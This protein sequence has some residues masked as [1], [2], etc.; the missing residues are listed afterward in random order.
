[1]TYKILIVDLKK[2]NIDFKYI[3]KEIESEYLSGSALGL[4]FIKKY[5]ISNFFA[6][7]STPL[8]LIQ[9]PISK[10]SIVSTNDKGEII[11]SSMGG[12][13]G[14]YL[15]KNSIDGLILLNKYDSYTSIF[16]DKDQVSFKNIGLYGLYNSQIYK[17]INEF[18]KNQAS[19]Y[20]AKAGI[21]KD[22]TARLIHN[23][24]HGVSK[25][26]GYYLAKKNILSIS[27]KI[28]NDNENINFDFSSFSKKRLKNCSL[29]PLGCRFPRKYKNKTIFDSD[30]NLSDINKELLK[31]IKYKLDEYGLDDIALSKSISFSY[32]HLN[33]IYN[34]DNLSYA[35][36]AL[37]VDNIISDY[38]KNIYRDL[39]QGESFLK[40]KYKIDSPKSK[41]KKYNFL[42]LLMDNIGM[43]FFANDYETTSELIDF[44]NKNFDKNYN[45]DDIRILA[46]KIEKLKKL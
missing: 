28:Y 13:F 46:S 16:I 24:N 21:N 12:E 17:K 20:I 41:E 10:F 39:A 11:E 44:I 34:F 38:R 15:K 33:D 8:N 42:A 6:I 7:F 31:E 32:N 2:Q 36:L 19:I 18:D 9:S 4:Y 45:E 23:I 43:C 27:V 25:G 5:E 40:S 30:K 14:Y 35:N 26:F 37:M 29:C 3:D 22:R 1:M